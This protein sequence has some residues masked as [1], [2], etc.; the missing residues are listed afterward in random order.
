VGSCPSE[1][2]EHGS[3]DRT[4]TGSPRKANGEGGVGGRPNVST[5]KSR[6]LKKRRKK[7]KILVTGGGG[8]VEHSIRRTKAKKNS[9]AKRAKTRQE[10][11][12]G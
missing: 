10:L 2:T 4:A 6:C 5:S 12:A 9:I 11:A 7:H 3:R 8:L 1:G